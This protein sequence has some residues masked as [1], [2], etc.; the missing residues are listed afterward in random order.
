[1][2]DHPTGCDRKPKAPLV[3]IL[4]FLKP[5]SYCLE[6]VKARFLET[7]QVELGDGI[8]IFATYG[9][10]LVRLSQDTEYF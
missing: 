1:M 10:K 9:S 2:R 4:S 8:S 5:I 6:I 3:A 7:Q